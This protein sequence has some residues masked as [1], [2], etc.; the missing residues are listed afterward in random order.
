MLSTL[1]LSWITAEL[2]VGGRYPMEAAACLARELGIRRVVDVRVEMVDD[3]DVLGAHGI[4][5]LHLPT[6]DRCA[7]SLPML[8]DGVAWVNAQLSA[9]HKVYV[10]CEH[11]IGRSAL[12]ACCVLVSR[13]LPPLDALELAK[14]RRPQVSPSPEQLQA[15]LA[16]LA[17]WSA[18]RA[19]AWTQPSLEELMRIAYR[20]LHAR[21]QTSAPG[22]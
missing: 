14:T 5:L 3:E 18:A 21:E 22:R 6:L 2:A 8:H 12:L 16:W 9:G 11:G 1:N 4:E 15:F 10:H 7:V 20:H 13:G 19:V 17:E